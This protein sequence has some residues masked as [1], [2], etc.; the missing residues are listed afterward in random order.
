M[1]TNNNHIDL[2]KLK[3]KSLSFSVPER[4]FDELPQMIQSKTSGLSTKKM[5]DWSYLFSWNSLK[6][7]FPAVLIAVS[8]LFYFTQPNT[9]NINEIE[10]ASLEEDAILDYLSVYEENEAT[11]YSLAYD[12]KVT[13][14]AEDFIELDESITNELLNELY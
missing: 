8:A 9:Q 11:I 14:E 4:Y 5:F 1:Q 3:K 2:K 10:W 7:A 6:Y 13:I 12:S